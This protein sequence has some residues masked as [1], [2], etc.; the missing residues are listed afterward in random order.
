MVTMSDGAIE[1]E[2]V[3]EGPK[4]MDAS[5]AVAPDGIHPAIAEPLAGVLVKTCTQLF[6]VLLDEGRLPH[7]RLSLTVVPAHKCGTEITVAAVDR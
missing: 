7:D 1:R 6:T 3:R 4:K 2:E 5:K